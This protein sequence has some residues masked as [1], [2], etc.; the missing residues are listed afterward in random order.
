MLIKHGVHREIARR[1]QR[2]IAKLRDLRV[3]PR[4]TRGNLA[5][6]KFLLSKI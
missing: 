5:P 3:F 6:C 4:C 1:A 2:Q